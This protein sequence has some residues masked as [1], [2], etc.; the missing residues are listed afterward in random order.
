MQE[1]LY[2]WYNARNVLGHTGSPSHCLAATRFVANV[3]R[4]RT[5]GKTSRGRTFHQDGKR[6]HAR[7]QNAGKITLSPTATSMWFYRR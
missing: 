2:D 5:S 6:F 4:K 7:L 3:S 1:R